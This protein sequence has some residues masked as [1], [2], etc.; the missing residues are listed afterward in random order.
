MNLCLIPGEQ[1]AQ[2]V[3]HIWREACKQA[4]HTLEILEPGQPATRKLIE[5]LHL[6][7][8]PALLLGDRILAVGNPTPE[9]ARQVL[10]SLDE[11]HAD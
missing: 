9:S 7:T 10:A 6:N 3:T 8:F 5:R 2:D 4:N 1:P 11:A